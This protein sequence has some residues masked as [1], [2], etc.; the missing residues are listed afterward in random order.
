MRFW[1]LLRMFRKFPTST[2]VIFIG[3]YSSWLNAPNPSPVKVNGEDLPTTEE[4]TYL[5]IIV[6]HD[7]GAGSD[8]KNRLS[9]AR[10]AF[11]MLNN[12]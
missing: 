5:D 12:V 2:P 1:Y 3:E 8:I 10:N 6:R 4:F 11:R 9:K 7:G